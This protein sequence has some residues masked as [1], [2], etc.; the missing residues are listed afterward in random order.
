MNTEET[1]RML[2]A[3]VARIKSMTIQRSKRVNRSSGI[4]LIAAITVSV[5]VWFTQNPV[6]RDDAHLSL[7]LGL[8]AAVFCLGC[9]FF[10][11]LYPIPRAKCPR[12]GC[13]WNV[14]S[15][16][17]TQEWLAW[18]SC[19]SCGLKMADDHHKKS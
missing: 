17:D 15:D 13:D 18:N 10:R 8:G 14:E 1:D 16:N 12:C 3:E 6:D 9:I 2:S 11:F 7:S 5:A 19:P 4:L